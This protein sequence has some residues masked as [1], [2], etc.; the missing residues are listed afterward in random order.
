MA[1]VLLMGC[2][3]PEP[4]SVSLQEAAVS[5]NAQAI[6]QHAAAGSDLDE[7]EP[8][9]GS[10]PLITAATFG[11]AEAVQALIEGGADVNRRNND[12][13]TALHAAAFLCRAEIV[14]ILLAAGAD[15][16]AINK[17]GAT[18]LQSVEAP[19]DQVKGIY[20]LLATVLGPLGLKLDYER[21]QAERPR[22]AAI[23]KG[24]GP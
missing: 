12:G 1:A 3:K 21:I 5:G 14:E 15:R 2:S 11:Q 13:T 23:L 22:I 24:N 8:T 20:D 18:A 17:S 7:G 16:N 10:T 19:F 6:R 9:N 4:P